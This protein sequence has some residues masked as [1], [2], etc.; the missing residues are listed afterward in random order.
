MRIKILLLL[1]TLSIFAFAVQVS[2]AQSPLGPGITLT[3]QTQT[4]T[5]G[6]QAQ[7]GATFYYAEI[8]DSI[9][10]ANQ[11]IVFF[12]ISGPNQ[13]VSATAIT[14][15]QGQATFTYTGLVPGIDTVRARDTTFTVYSN[16]VTVT[17][18]GLPNVIPE[19]PFGTIMIVAVMTGCSGF[20]LMSKRRKKV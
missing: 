2:L 20:Y 5:V 19:V 7:I 3:P 16:D 9:P 15:A 12:V 10:L 17:W 14:N 13:N 1:L 4:H 8:N 11:T 6:E 18:V